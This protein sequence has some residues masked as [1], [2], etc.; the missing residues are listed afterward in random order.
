M[1]D[2]FDEL[3][4]YLKA[5]TS[6]T[7]LIGSGTACRMYPDGAKQGA[8]MPFA[9][10][11]QVSGDSPSTLS[12]SS[13]GCGIEMETI[14]VFAV[15]STKS[16]AAELQEALRLKLQNYRGL[17]GSTHVRDCTI[18]GGKEQGVDLPQDGSDARRYWCK[19]SY[20]FWHD[21]PIS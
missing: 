17:M 6:I 9:F 11:E 1:A 7:S 16:A 21:L 2:F 13:R 18:V 20:Q 10:M 3:A 5:Q 8:T 15:G 19:R 12:T 14:D 4:T